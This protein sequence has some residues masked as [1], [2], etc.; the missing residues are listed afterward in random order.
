MIIFR[1]QR[2]YR[3]ELSIINK[4]IKNYEA[5]AKSS[6]KQRNLNS[7]NACLSWSLAK[8]MGL[9][10][11]SGIPAYLNEDVD[12]WFRRREIVK[13]RLKK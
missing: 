1:K 3:K 12:S 13:K 7:K 6:I 10:T 2:E 4:A 8:S 9:L 11:K 5:E